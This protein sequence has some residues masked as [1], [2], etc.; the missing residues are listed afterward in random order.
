[1]RARRDR[2]RAHAA[3]LALAAAALLGACGDDDSGS[4]AAA[5]PNSRAAYIER[6]DEI[7]QDL[8]EQRAP[9]E[10]RAARAGQDGDAETAAQTFDDAAEI[11]RNRVD[12]LAGLP[13]PEGDA[14]RADAFVASAR[15]TVEPAEQAAEALS[16]D[17]GAALEAAGQRGLRATTRFNK[18]AIAYGFEVCGR[19]AAA[20]IG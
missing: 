17:D 3:A 1:M 20:E 13:V 12:E 4:E 7:C 2:H 16:E 11:T 10:V 15:A 8:Y 9:L 14:A 5:E 6:G 19:G 18:V